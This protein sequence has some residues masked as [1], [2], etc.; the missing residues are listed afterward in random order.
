MEIRPAGSLDA[1]NPEPDPQQYII[2]RDLEIFRARRK[3]VK[4][5]GTWVQCFAVYMAAMA[6]QHA[7][8]VEEMLAYML[9]IVRAQKEF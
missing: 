2:I 8:V 3:P 7:E 5:I 9:A 1:V 6:K 4:D